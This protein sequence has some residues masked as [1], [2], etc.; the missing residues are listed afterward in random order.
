MPKK[1]VLL[2]PFGSTSCPSPPVTAVTNQETG[3]VLHV[4][5]T[6]DLWVPFSDKWEAVFSL[7]GAYAKTQKVW[8]CGSWRRKEGLRHLV[9]RLVRFL[10]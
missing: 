9:D 3:I 5:V 4:T 8:S 10:L 6:A 7:T 2:F 1:G